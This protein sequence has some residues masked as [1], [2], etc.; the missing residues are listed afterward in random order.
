M[1]YNC[2]KKKNMAK[3][4]NKIVVADQI[5]ILSN[6]KIKTQEHVFVSK[7]LGLADDQQCK[8]FTL[9]LLLFLF[10]EHW[11]IIRSP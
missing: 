2:G 1:V 9:G 7:T 6:P 3:K 10:T 8:L 4:N 5:L 11:Y